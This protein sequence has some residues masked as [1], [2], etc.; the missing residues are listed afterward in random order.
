MDHSCKDD[1]RPAAKNLRS[2][3]NLESVMTL[4]V[5]ITIALTMALSTTVSLAQDGQGA[6]M[7]AL[8]EP[9]TLTIE[10][11]P[12]LSALERV[13]EA[14]G[15]SVHMDEEVLALL[16]H[17]E[18]TRVRITARN[19]K[20]SKALTAMLDPMGLRW[21]A[22]GSHVLV[23]ATEPLRRIGRRPTFTEVE[24]LARLHSE[25]LKPGDSAIRQIRTLTGIEELQL[26]WHQIEPSDRA[27]A[28]A[29]ADRRLPC[30][31]AEYLDRLC[32]GRELTWYV[33]GTNV[34]IVNKKTQA[35]RQLRRITTVEYRS[36][37]LDQVIYDLARKANL[38]LKM[39]PGV[40]NV[41]AAQ[42]RRDFTLLMDQATIEE[43]LEAISG[44]TGLVFGIEGLA[45]RVSAAEGA[46]PQP[47]PERK[48][49]AFVVTMAVT[50]PDGR[51]YRVMFR[52]DD[53]PDEFV[54]L[55]TRKKDALL[56]EIRAK[57]GVT[58]QPV[59]P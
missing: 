50:G 47:A 38:K 6:L 43:A 25:T 11:M 15:L 39:D 14:T 24:I 13:A 34:M 51:D 20:L 10:D 54:E 55:I 21:R 58:T 40:M 41:V 1:R 17:G 26:A 28:M 52:P 23:S 27:T 5:A 12:I 59:K 36:R 22:E 56:E 3:S 46:A 18:E 7:R 44:A 19:V 37:P 42:T 8:D 2:L 9:F 30:T 31:G 35:M 4:R 45:L 16:P 57:Y 32:H 48:R 53:L 49:S 33:W 29:A